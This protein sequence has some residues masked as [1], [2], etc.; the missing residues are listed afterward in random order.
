MIRRANARCVDD[1]RYFLEQ[2]EE[3]FADAFAHHFLMPDE[4][5]KP[6]V[7]DAM[8]VDEIAERLKVSVGS[9][10]LR[11]RYLEWDLAAAA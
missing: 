4:V 8:P 10:R 1:E 9:V 3:Y 6:M 2:P 7:L 5:L 11:L